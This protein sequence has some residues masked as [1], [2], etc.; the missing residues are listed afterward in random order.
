MYSFNILYN[1]ILGSRDDGMK[2][3][4][5]SILLKVDDILIREHIYNKGSRLISYAE[6]NRDY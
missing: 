4:T 3:L 2:K 1:V 5:E 6:K